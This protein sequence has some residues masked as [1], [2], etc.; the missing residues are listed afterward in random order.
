MHL[1]LLDGNLKHAQAR[2]R[3]RFKA[4]YVSR[5]H[6][7][8]IKEKNKPVWNLHS[9]KSKAIL[10]HISDFVYMCHMCNFNKI[11]STLV[12]WL[13]L[14]LMEGELIF[15]HGED[16]KEISIA[17]GLRWR[18]EVSPNMFDWMFQLGD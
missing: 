5:I 18:K 6:S 12:Q 1:Q 4:D 13:T 9:F 11:L 2:E 15:E 7:K 16:A 14:T 10:H 8:P 3:C 17:G